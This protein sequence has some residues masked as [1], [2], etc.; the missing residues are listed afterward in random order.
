MQ[1]PWL[2]NAKQLTNWEEQY[3][4]QHPP[5]VLRFEFKQSNLPYDVLLL[6]Q[7]TKLFQFSKSTIPLHSSS[8]HYLDQTQF[9][10]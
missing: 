2:Y 7:L 10:H 9:I 5:F 8:I 1:Q 3:A 4:M 6:E